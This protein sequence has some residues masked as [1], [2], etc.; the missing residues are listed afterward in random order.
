MLRKL[1]QEIL[2]I[3]ER[4]QIVGLCSFHNAVNDCGSLGSIDCI[5]HLPI[6]LPDTKTPDCPFRCVIINRDVSIREKYTEIFF[7]IQCITYSITKF[8]LFGYFYGFQVRK[9]RI[10]KWSYHH[11]SLLKPFIRR[12]VLQFPFFPVDC[13]N[14][15]HQQKYIR[16]LL[17]GFRD[18]LQSLIKSAAAMNPAA[19][20]GQFFQL[21]F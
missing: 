15:F 14:L 4:L 12:K 19:G 8:I 9:K 6:L 17:T 7:L 11:L 1:F 21:F 20:N 18:Q 2:H 3:I 16:L 5:D 13:L 10:H